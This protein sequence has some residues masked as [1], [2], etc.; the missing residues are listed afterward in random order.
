MSIDVLQDKIR[1]LKNP[2][3]VGL[4]PT[5][6]LIP[7]HILR[8]AYAQYGETPAGLAAAYEVFCME[9]LD[10]LKDTVPAV[11][12]QSVCFEVLGGPGIAVMERVAARA[13][14]L[15]YY[16]VV[17]AL[18]S[19]APHIA[20][21]S[22]KRLFGRLS[23]GGTALEPFP[24][25]GVTLNGYMG[26]ESVRPYLPYCKED[27]KNIF[28]MLRSSNRSGREVQDLLTGGRTVH[29][30]MA[31]LLMRWTQDTYGRFGYSE[32]AALVGAYD[33][34][35][36]AELRRLYPKVFFLVTGYGAQ[37][38]TAKPVSNAFDLAGHGAVVAASRSIIGAWK[39]EE[40]DGT[41]YCRLALA[42]ALKMKKSLAGYIIVM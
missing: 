25:D 23:I 42:A 24:C 37:G 2:S 30:A 39:S 26:S 11:K 28:L 15:G 29:T 13:R 5:E 22:A 41:D 10:T 12:L 3:M 7:L 4:D 1:A 36:L 34:A 38:G 6:D 35:A 32:V 19:D 17:D 31:D 9:L 16:V 8:P 21:L 20:E 14:E 27:K 18:R 33:G 40:S